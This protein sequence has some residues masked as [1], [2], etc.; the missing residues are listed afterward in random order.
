MQLFY[1]SDIKQG[2]TSFF[3]DKEESKHIV[4][5]LRKKEG[6]KVFITNGLGFLFES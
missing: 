4:K 5:V 1:N 2:I 6:D 3:F